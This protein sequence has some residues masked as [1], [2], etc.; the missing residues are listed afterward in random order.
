MFEEQAWHFVEIGRGAPAVEAAVLG[1]GQEVV[2]R[3]ATF[4]VEKYVS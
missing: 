1:A 4:C 2:Q 3:V